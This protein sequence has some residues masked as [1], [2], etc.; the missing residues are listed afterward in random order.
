MGFVRILMPARHSAF[1]SLLV[2]ISVLAG[3]LSAQ[4]MPRSTIHSGADYQDLGP[5]VEYYIDPTRS[6]N[7]SEIRDLDDVLWQK[8]TRPSIG[9]GFT[10]AVY[11]FRVHVT[12][13]S[14]DSE[15]LLHAGNPKFD[16]IDTYQY[17][18]EEVIHHKMG[19]GVPRSE[20][21][22]DHR[23]HLVPFEINPGEETTILLRAE[24]TSTFLL[25]LRLWLKTPFFENDALKNLWS[26]SLLGIWL[27]VMIFLLV[28]ISAFKHSSVVSFLSFTLFFGIHQFSALGLGRQYWGESITSYDTIF[29]FSIGAAIVSVYPFLSNLLKLEKTSRISEIALRVTAIGS[30][31]CMVAYL[32]IDYA[33]VI[34]YLVSLTIVMATLIV[35]VCGYA[36]FQGNRLA[37][38]STIAC[39][40]LGV[41]VVIQA[42]IS[43]QL[44]NAT[45]VTD[46]VG[47]IAFIVMIISISFVISAE[48]RQQRRLQAVFAQDKSYL[49][50]KQQTDETKALES[51]VH[52]RTLELETALHELSSAHETLKELNTV[53]VMTGI[54]NRNYFDTAFEQEWRRAIRQ[55][56]PISLMLLDVDHFK[57]V[58]DTHGHLIGDECLRAIV[59][60]IRSVLRR[61]ADI[62]A[63]YGGEEFVILLPY[64]EIDN[65][66]FLAEQIRAKIEQSELQLDSL[67]LRATVSIGVGSKPPTE[68]ENHKDFIAA[69]DAALYRAKDAGRNNVQGALEKMRS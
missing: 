29:V 63:R 62:L 36:A 2:L 21:P 18:G 37:L 42:L 9:F 53:D 22:I 13:N 49:E 5:I 39:A 34:P 68:G 69:V 67:V 23:E 4:A 26:G 6:L 52:N 12:N 33:R 58:N 65:A 14:I 11:W 64:L 17:T 15:F 51:Q 32:F 1:I 38:Y 40:I 20:K 30:A 41:S 35:L 60:I 43:L 47:P 27:I 57:Q 66:M 45:H 55:G 7:V 59:L 56:H 44:M 31:L 24:T 10:D 48:L 28:I 46:Q 16:Y 8:N 25:P 3:S 50:R 54:K 61:P 19:V